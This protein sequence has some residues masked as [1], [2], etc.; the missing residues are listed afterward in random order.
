MK[1]AAYPGWQLPVVPFGLST[2][3]I[4][5]VLDLPGLPGVGNKIYD[6]SPYGNIGTIT[7]AAWIRLPSG[8]WVLSFDGS[9]DYVI[10]PDASSLD[11]TGNLTIRCW[12][13]RGTIGAYMR[14]AD[15]GTG[16]Y[17][18]GF[19]NTNYFLFTIAGVI[20][21]PST[22]LV[23]TDT[24]AYH[25]IAVVRTGE[26]GNWDY[27][28]YLDGAEDSTV[29]DANNLTAND[30]DLRIGVCKNLANAFN[31]FIALP[32]ICNRALSALEIQKYYQQEKHLF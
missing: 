26:A 4:G 8:L 24:T 6:R 1:K 22:G 13:K 19:I 3:P 29:N 18:F 16:N 7:G 17:A 12:L 25:Q 9:D 21:I 15:K 32:R 5:C 27:I 28:F 23:L 14:I 2:P 31:G 20:D 10:I 11:L 30:E